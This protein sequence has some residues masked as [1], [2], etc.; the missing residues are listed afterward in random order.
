MDLIREKLI[1]DLQLENPCPICIICSE[2]ECEW[3]DGDGENEPYHRERILEQCYEKG[4]VSLY[5]KWKKILKFGLDIGEED[6]Y[7]ELSQLID[8]CLLL[9]QNATQFREVI[10]YCLSKG[11]DIY[12]SVYIHD[13]HYMDED[14]LN[15]L[16]NLRQYFIKL[17]FNS[18]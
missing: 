2:T 15:F 6:D 8:H 17:H 9:R 7:P 4:G 13:P 5:A 16:H 14:K 10:E 1:K 11:Y 18:F 12:R 3:D